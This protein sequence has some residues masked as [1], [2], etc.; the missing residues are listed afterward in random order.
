LIDRIPVFGGYPSWIVPTKPRSPAKLL[1]FPRS[2][3][4]LGRCCLRM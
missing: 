3:Q 1:E 2:S 4:K